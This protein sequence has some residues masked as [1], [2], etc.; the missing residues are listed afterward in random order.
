MMQLEQR[1]WLY[2]QRSDHILAASSGHVQRR[3]RHPMELPRL[4]QLNEPKPST[5]GKYL[6]TRSKMYLRYQI[7]SYITVRKCYIVHF[8]LMLLTWMHLRSLCSIVIYFI[9][10]LRWIQ[11][12]IVNDNALALSTPV[13]NSLFIVHCFR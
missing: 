1:Q 7:Y 11:L 9:F 3:P 10:I 2:H 12:Y 4:A 13:Y 8:L 5:I 6:S